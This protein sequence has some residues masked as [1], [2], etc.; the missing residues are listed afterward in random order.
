MAGMGERRPRATARRTATDAKIAA[1]VLD[2]IREHGVRAVTI[3]AVT[4][5]SGV[6]KTTIY[7]R[8]DDRFDL[9][10]GVLEILAPAPDYTARAVTKHGLA[11][12]L[13][14]VLGAFEERVGL[15]DVGQVLA[16][17]DAFLREWRE[18]VVTPRLDALLEYLD[19]G[20]ADGAFDP[21]VDRSLVVDMVIGAMIVRHAR[22]GGVPEAWA[23]S[24]VETIWPLLRHPTA[25]DA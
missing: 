19:R 3:D 1:A 2:I 16:G 6:A 23:A 7:R 21:D 25:G 4:A 10:A 5:H 12:V 13:R 9:L 17:E 14:D 15:A 20:A 18:K 22:S 8:Y 11:E 24:V